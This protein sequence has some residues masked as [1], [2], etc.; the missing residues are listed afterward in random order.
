MHAVLKIQSL[1]VSV[2]LVD[3]EPEY[4]VQSKCTYGERLSNHVKLLEMLWT[5]Y[6]L[7]I[8]FSTVPFGYPTVCACVEQSFGNI[9][10]NPGIVRWLFANIAW[11][12]AT[13][14]SF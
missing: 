1:A 5:I 7:T 4:M 2:K 3:L 12:A 6:T 14:C 13:V 9:H 8:L 10:P 11:R